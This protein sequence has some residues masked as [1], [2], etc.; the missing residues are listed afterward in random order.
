VR[1]VAKADNKSRKDFAQSTDC[2]YIE[3]QSLI[4]TYGGSPTVKQTGFRLKVKTGIRAGQGYEVRYGVVNQ[5]P[6]EGGLKGMWVIDNAAYFTDRNVSFD[7][8]GGPLQPGAC[9]EML[10]NPRLGTI[11]QMRSG[12]FPQCG[13][14]YTAGPGDR[15]PMVTRNY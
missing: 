8:T 10:Y 4:E 12:N 15:P 2:W 14:T 3:Q 9:V 7:M 13:G 1:R 6:T 5:L 11:H